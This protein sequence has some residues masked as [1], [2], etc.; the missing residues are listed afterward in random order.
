MDVFAC[1]LKL[2]YVGED[3]FEHNLMTFDQYPENES[4][5]TTTALIHNNT[6]PGVG[7]QKIINDKASNASLA[8]NAKIVFQSQ[9]R[10]LHSINKHEGRIPSSYSN[11]AFYH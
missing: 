10:T 4:Y 11:L 3:I 9:M 2:P 1:I 7:Y 8:P 5:L 6:N